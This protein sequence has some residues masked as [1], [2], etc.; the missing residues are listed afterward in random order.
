MSCHKFYVVC[1]VPDS[2]P[3]MIFS[4]GLY[5]LNIRIDGEIIEIRTEGI[6]LPNVVCNMFDISFHLS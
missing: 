5:P 2:S 1:V 4:S 6:D 3:E